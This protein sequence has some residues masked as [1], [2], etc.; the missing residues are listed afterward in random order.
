[1]FS[2]LIPTWNNLAY[3][4]HCI[5]SIKAHSSLHHQIIVI[6]N[7]GVDGTID[8]L[9]QQKIEFIHHP[10]NVGICV[11]L[12]SATSLISQ[13]YV[14][15]LNDDMYVLPHWDSTL[16]N[17]ILSIDHAQ[18][19]LSG[20]MIE[21]RD[22]GNACV[23]VHD[24]G[25]DLASFNE[26]ELLEYHQAS[27]KTDWNGAS[28]PPVLL[29]TSLWKKVGGMSE[30]FSPGMYSDP[31]LSMKLW[32]N[33]VRYFKGVGASRVYHFGSKSTRKLGKNVGRQLFLNKWKITPNYFYKNYLKMGTA[34][35]GSLPEHKQPLTAKW[36]HKLKQTMGK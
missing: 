35:I 5:H 18:F 23:L 14:V 24:F 27:T 28:W 33:G 6:V 34:F 9:K 26:K 1:M 11:G 30:E 4:K 21:P 13:Q 7:E 17:E 25:D 15:Y 36:V 29:P 22:T 20:T 31:D 3:L 2:I 12:N 32:N 10:Q 19:M 16:A 8:W